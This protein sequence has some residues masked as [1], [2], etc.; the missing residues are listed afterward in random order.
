LTDE[1]DFEDPPWATTVQVIVARSMIV[2]GT[3]PDAASCPRRLRSPWKVTNR[4]AMP[5]RIAFRGAVGYCG[6]L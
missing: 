3:A 1:S 4:Q 5:Q 6:D 2:I